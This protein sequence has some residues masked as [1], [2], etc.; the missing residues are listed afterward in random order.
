MVDQ[1]L[2]FRA[3]TRLKDILGRGLIL[4]DN[5]AIIELIKNGKDANSG[6]V[7]IQFTDAWFESPSSKIVVTDYGDG[8]SIEDFK[9]KWLN[10]AYSEKRNK[11]NNGRAYAGDK[12]VGRFSCDRL[13][14]RLTLISRKKGHEPFQVNID[15]R[16]FEVD[17]IDKEISDINIQ[18]GLVSKS[19]H[20][21]ILGSK[22]TGTVLI[23]EDL[24]SIWGWDK[25]EKL[26]K[27]LERFIIDPGKKFK[28]RLRSEDIQDD[29]GNLVFDGYV[30]NK[31]FE[32]LDAKTTSVYSEISEQGRNISLEIRQNG[33]VILSY[34]IPNPYVEL[35]G[36][37][38][39][40]HIYYL[41]TG[42]KISFKNITGYRSFE[43]G[44]IM[45]FLNGFR[46]MPYGE[47][48]NDWLGINRRK[49]Q[50]TS[51]Y[52]GARE[53]FGRVEIEDES[54]TLIP[55]SSREGVENNHAFKELTGYSLSDSQTAKRGFIHAAFLALETYVVRGLD[56]DRVEPK[57]GKF[58]YGETLN[59][60][61]AAVNQ[62]DNRNKLAEVKIN[63]AEIRK[64]ARAKIREYENFVTDLKSDVANKQVYELTPSE[65][66]KVKKFVDRLDS[67][68]QAANETSK[69]LKETTKELKK[70]AKAEKAR[71]LFL[72]ARFKPDSKK[73]AELIHHIGVLSRKIEAELKD[74][75]SV[76]EGK[77]MQQK[78]QDQGVINRLH[79][80][81][82][83]NGKLLKL[84]EIVS[85]ADFNLMTDDITEDI[86]A[87]VEQYVER[88]VE[89]KSTLN[90]KLEY[91]N[92]EQLILPLT[93]SPLEVTMMIDNIL[94]NAARANAKRM[95]VKVDSS[96][97][98]MDLS[99]MNDGDPLTEEFRAEDLFKPG[100]TVT[101]GSG[102]G[103]AQVKR[104]SKRLE[105]VTSIS[106][107][108][109]NRVIVRIRW[110]N[111]T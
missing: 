10:I 63:E 109:K 91:K 76:L 6:E 60:M 101:G 88:L 99:F 20:E 49:A 34:K 111:E 9:T 41:N 38:A 55:I 28:V 74:A 107:T 4:N 46:V 103:L 45:M 102:I 12:G 84:S 61:L 47:P 68:L 66:R 18:G 70:T 67:R 54:R 96:N 105:A 83:N 73:V 75:A 85:D 81:I 17:D 40:V 59:A 2:N 21:K 52:L 14:R 1:S 106:E 92:L 26:R 3:N 42:A 23:I 16:D 56:W 53:V 69:E 29:E 39:K 27:E 108:K 5:V 93:F 8:M 51:R 24:R 31:L 57:G 110:E 104:V 95:L 15:W 77:P 100:V 89:N 65:K 87:F 44:S 19:H 79:S 48:E 32:K 50:G 11:K 82:F 25:L 37:S 22:S 97:G 33:I 30:E 43:Y 72:E 98:D 36:V 78:I 64:I 80:A 90:I 62:I 71:R 94:D 35:L 13:G 58:S 86:F 7:Q